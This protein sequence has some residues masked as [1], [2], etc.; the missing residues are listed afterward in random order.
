MTSSA[1]TQNMGAGRTGQFPT[2][3]GGIARLAYAKLVSAGGD[4]ELLLSKAGLTLEEM[5]NAALRGWLTF[6]IAVRIGP[7]GE[8]ASVK[9]GTDAIA[10][11]LSRDRQ[12]GR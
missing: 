7:P 8:I 4:A 11:Y 2:A 3:T 1:V 12:N 5:R 9:C 6:T 10:R